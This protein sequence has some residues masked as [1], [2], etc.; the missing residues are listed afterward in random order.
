MAQFTKTKTNRK[1]NCGSLIRLN[2]SESSKTS[3]KPKKTKNQKKQNENHHCG[4]KSSR[5][6]NGDFCFG[7]FWFFWF[8]WFSR[9]FG[10][11]GFM[12]VGKGIIAVSVFRRPERN[13]L[14]MRMFSSSWPP[15]VHSPEPS[16]SVSRRV[17]VSVCLRLL[18]LL[19]RGPAWPSY[20]FHVPRISEFWKVD[21]SPGRARCNCSGPGCARCDRFLPRPR[22]L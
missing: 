13:Q 10:A 18:L 6:R 14:K 15:L 22:P 2:N 12:I 7:F 9:G 17:S 4:P 16:S 20:S 5:T 1:N 19:L 21:P 3:R 11:F 8:F